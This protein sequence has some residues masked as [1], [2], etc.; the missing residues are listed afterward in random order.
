MNRLEMIVAALEEDVLVPVDMYL[1][2]AGE[3]YDLSRLNDRIDGF[4]IIDTFLNDLESND[5]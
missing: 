2:L 4:S 1:Q 5:Y 3:G